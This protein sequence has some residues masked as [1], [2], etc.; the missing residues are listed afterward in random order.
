MPRSTE[1]AAVITDVT[2]SREIGEAVFQRWRGSRTERT[3][4]DDGSLYHH[5]LLINLL[6]LR[7]EAS[8]SKQ[9][10]AAPDAGVALICI[11]E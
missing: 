2:P 8:A 9:L 7:R 3:S 4:D 6:A 10:R 5:E 1:I 11:K